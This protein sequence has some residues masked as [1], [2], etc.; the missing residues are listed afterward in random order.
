MFHTSIRPF[1]P[2]EGTSTL[3]AFA[4]LTVLG[5][6]EIRNCRVVEGRNGLFATGPQ[7]KDREGKWR[8]IVVLSDEARKAIV[9][10]YQALVQPPVSA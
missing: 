7:E 1:T 10:A 8:D 4:T 6:G 5:V 2:K 9:S 3:K